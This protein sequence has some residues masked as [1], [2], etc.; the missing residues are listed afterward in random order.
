VLNGKLSDAKKLCEDIKN[1]FVKLKSFV[2][3]QDW[4]QMAKQ[5]NLKTISNK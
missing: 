5:Q 1:E 3:D 4:I 2:S